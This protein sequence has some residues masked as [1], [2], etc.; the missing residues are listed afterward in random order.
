MGRLFVCPSEPPTKCLMIILF[1]Y[2]LAKFFAKICFKSF[3]DFCIIKIEK[4]ECPKSIRNYEKNN[5]WNI[6]CLVGGSLGQTN[7]RPIV[8]YIRLTEF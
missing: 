2:F 1:S 3:F 8:I 5:A 7:K 4:I 6:R